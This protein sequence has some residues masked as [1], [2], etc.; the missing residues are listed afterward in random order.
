MFRLVFFLSLFISFCAD[1]QTTIEINLKLESYP[2]SYFKPFDGFG[3]GL[4]PTEI[5]PDQQGKI[6][7][8][9]KIIKP[10]FIRLSLKGE[11]LWLLVEPSDKILIDKLPKTKNEPMDGVHIYG[12]NEAGHLFYNKYY[13][14]SPMDKISGV[15]E[16][17]NEAVYDGDVIFEK[18]KLEFEKQ[19]AWVDSLRLGNL[20]TE[21][22][23]AYMK[24]EI[25]CIIGWEVGNLCDNHFSDAKY[26][27][28]LVK[29]KTK[30]FSLVD[31]LDKKI[32]TCGFAS[33]YCY[34]YY[35]FL[36]TE[37]KIKADT[38]QL[39]IEP[40]Y[41][42]APLELRKY[43][44]AEL[45]FRSKRSSPSMYN[46]CY[47]FKK[48]KAM[49]KEGDYID[50]FERNGIC[51]PK[52]PESSVKVIDITETDLFRLL[53][54]NFYHKRV[55]IDLWATWCAPCKM[56]FVHYDSSFYNF[57]KKKKIELVYLSVDKPELKNRWEKEVKVL[58]LK[59]YHV[60][61]DKTLQASIKEIVYDD[62]TV[63]IPRYILI[64]ET[65]KILSA[66]FKR[67][68]D[69]LFKLEIN[70]FFQK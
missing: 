16:I 52:N 49:F 18:L 8:D 53:S 36:Y 25:K 59:G 20:I 62:G 30:L 2:I 10:T 51:N 39:I 35:Q 48:Y 69:P 68:S 43:M 22:Y 3:N 42:L 17:F 46:Y 63:I 11:E 58:N 23:S 1:S 66:D 37:N 56:E 7:I 6:V 45:I 19:V 60:L 32:Y 67:P 5:M 64:D 33:G 24:T 21:Q 41:V 54:E 13:N 29:V 70:S 31:P 65:G 27:S 4:I 9:L 55:F 44:W 38:A 12:N 26:H 34:T 50:Y 28:E 61:A 15:R 57:M 40:Y 14:Y 47:L